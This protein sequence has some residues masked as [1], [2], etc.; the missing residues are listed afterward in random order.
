MGQGITK[1]RMPFETVLASI[2]GDWYDIARFYRK[3]AVLQPWCSKG[4]LHT[5]PR[6]AQISDVV[7]WMRV[8]G[9]PEEVV[10][11]ALDFQRFFRVPVGLHWY[12][13]HQIP[14]DDRYPE[15]F[16]PK[17]GFQAA[18]RQ[19]RESGIVVMPYINARLWDSKTESWKSE[20]ARSAS[21]KDENLA[22]YV[23][24]YGSKVPLT[25]MC[26]TTRLWQTKMRSVVTRLARYGVHGVYLDQIG[27]SP[28]KLCFD[29]GHG[30]PL[31][32]GSWWV[33][34][35]RRLIDR[36]REAATRIDPNFF[37]TTESNAE[38]WIDRI[39]A[40]LMC[41]TTEGD[42]IP[43]FPAIYGDMTLMFGAYIFRRD[44]EGVWPFRTKVSQMF[45]WGVQL[46]WLGPEILEEGFRNEAL[47]LRELARVYLQAMEFLRDGVMLRPPVIE[48]EI[49]EVRTSW[50]L[51][52]RTWRIRMPAA[53]A[54]FWLRPDGEVGLVAYNMVDDD[55]ELEVSVDRED[56]GWLDLPQGDVKT[57]T[58]ASAYPRLKNGRLHFEIEIEAR[59]ALFLS[60]H[61]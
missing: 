5:S 35:Y 59:S 20:G 3:C 58:L 51:W 53:Q 39:D 38:T 46:G 49:E 26:P 40:L 14:F 2:H 42:V 37:L 18:V 21:T 17:D 29:P 10:D 15:Y 27:A 48:N 1:F 47:Y 45:L 36:V 16:P 30:H 55:V 22:P 4:P 33:D 11:K 23:E 32:G 60:T 34:G 61:K 13:W 31:G 19:L 52:G 12:G 6:P 9:D 44:L 54:S 50:E 43:I 41:N 57:G 8:D 28:P 24:T 7:L 25:P 56:V